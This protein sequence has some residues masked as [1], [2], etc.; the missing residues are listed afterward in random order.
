MVFWS[1]TLFYFLSK[2]PKE[3]VK[4]KLPKIQHQMI[5]TRAKTLSNERNAQIE[6][7]NSNRWAIK[8]STT[9]TIGISKIHVRDILIWYLMHR[10]N[11][12]GQK[13]HKISHSFSA[14]LLLA[15]DTK[16]NNQFHFRQPPYRSAIFRICASINKA[17]NIFHQYTEKIYAFIVLSS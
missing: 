4:Q 15:V 12:N 17:I 10:A 6:L 16:H 5:E 2:N 9:F 1:I 13:R 7:I 8:Y 14:L 3:T 11:S